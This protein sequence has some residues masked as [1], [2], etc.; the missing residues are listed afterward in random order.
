MSNLSEFTTINF[1][2]NKFEENTSLLEKLSCGICYEIPMKVVIFTCCPKKLLCNNCANSILKSKLSC[3][4]CRTVN[5]NV[6]TIEFAQDMI[7]ELIAKC[8][9]PDCEY[10]SPLKNMIYHEKN[11]CSHRLIPSLDLTTS[12]FNS[13]Q[14]II[15]PPSLDTLLS[16]TGDYYIQSHSHSLK[17]TGKL[18]HVD[19]YG[20][21]YNNTCNVKSYGCTGYIE[22]I[23]GITE[24]D[25]FNNYYFFGARCELCDFDVCMHCLISQQCMQL[26][27]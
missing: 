23:P 26:H 20:R 2:Y 8:C 12:S 10:K 6:T 4:F 21:I 14:Q 1:P 22:Q 17:I 11:I 15:W 25:S 13:F 5:P 3:S 16:L 24:K 9:Y 18:S 19:K 27:T 7:D